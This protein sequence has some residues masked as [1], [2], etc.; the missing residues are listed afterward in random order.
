MRRKSKSNYN[1]ARNDVFIDWKFGKDV[2]QKQEGQSE[3]FERVG[4]RLTGPTRLMDGFVVGIIMTLIH[5][6]VSQ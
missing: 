2:F 5:A 6:H 1:G 3:S 4:L